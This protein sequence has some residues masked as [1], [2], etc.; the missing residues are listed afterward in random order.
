MARSSDLSLPRT[1]FSCRRK[2]S[3]ASSS[4]SEDRIS[5]S[6]MAHSRELFPEPASPATTA[7]PEYVPAVS[8]RTRSSRRGT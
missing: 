7:G 8:A 6:A 5:D 4:D 3:P 2:R 1:F